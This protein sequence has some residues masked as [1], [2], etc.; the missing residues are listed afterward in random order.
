MN[1]TFTQKIISV[2][3]FSILTHFTHAQDIHLSHIHA[4]PTVLN[5]AMNG[6]FSGQARVIGN[7]RSQW[8]AITKGYK[9]V[10]GS[11][12]MKLFLVNKNDIISGGIQLYADRAGDLNYTSTSAALAFS[13]LKAFD[14]EGK[15]FVSLGIQNAFA[16]NRVDYSKIKTFDN[17]PALANGNISDQVTY[18]DV[19]AGISWFYTPSKYK[20]YYLGFSAFHLNNPQVSFTNDETPGATNTLL[21]RYNF[22]GG[23]SIRVSRELT[24]KPNFAFIQQGPHQEI[25]FGSF[26]R[27]KT[28]KGGIF[29]K[30]LHYIFFGAWVRGHFKSTSAGFDGVIASVK[31][32]YRNIAYAISYDF[33]ISSLQTASLGRG[34][35][36]FSVIRIFDWERTER[37]RKVRCPKL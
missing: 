34:G 22:H 12:D 11:A 9:T 13:Y 21:R 3:F 6:L 23:A 4:S 28:F 35:M 30:P 14:K 24:F 17:I 37:K 33:N 32:Q 19:N 1:L 31:Y 26:M 16:S 10:V 5:P 8:N 7:A 27:Y 29:K 18:M 15:H 25:T 36:E 20:S 2:F